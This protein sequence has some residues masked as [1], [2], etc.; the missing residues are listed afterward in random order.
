MKRFIQIYLYFIYPIYSIWF[1]SNASLIMDNLSIVGNLKGMRFYFILWAIL[2]EIALG[3][4]FFPCIKKSTHKKIFTSMLL[5]SAA[6]FSI[7]ILLPYLP[8]SYPVLSELHITLSF[9]G[10]LSMLFVAALL[11]MNLSLIY[12][13]YPF[14]IM[15][16]GIYGCALGIYGA[17]YMSVNSLVEIFLGIILPIYLFHLKERLK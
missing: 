3:I 2:C 14:D 6:M 15:M 16:I 10:L 13:I 11:V 4:G 12:K 17:N 1:A 7:A 5:I 8:E 9:I